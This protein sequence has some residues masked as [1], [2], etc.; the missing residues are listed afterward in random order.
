MNL[1]ISKPKTVSDTTTC[2]TSEEFIISRIGRDKEFKDVGYLCVNP[3]LKEELNLGTYIYI[4]FSKDRDTG[5]RYLLLS[6]NAEYSSMAYR[7]SDNGTTV[8]NQSLFHE[9]AEYCGIDFK[10]TDTFH[11][12]YI[13]Y[14]ED[15]YGGYYACVDIS[16]YYATEGKHI[17]YNDALNDDWEELYNGK[18][19]D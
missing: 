1:E 17:P 16:R 14:V 8:N 2:A 19:V 10:N 13:E 15:E 18:D 6:G 11:F 3:P 9:I 4:A 12:P 7:L 5:G